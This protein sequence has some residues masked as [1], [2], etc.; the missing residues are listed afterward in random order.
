MKVKIGKLIGFC[1][2]IFAILF[3]SYLCYQNYNSSKEEPKKAKLV[4]CL[5]NK[6]V[7]YYQY[8]K[9]I[10]TDRA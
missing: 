10:Y 3:V 1:F 8:Y 6:G 2:I 7:D 5:E 4:F 9:G